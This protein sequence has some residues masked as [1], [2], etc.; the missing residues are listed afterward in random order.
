MPSNLMNFGLQGF[1]TLVWSLGPSIAMSFSPSLSGNGTKFAYD[2]ADCDPLLHLHP[3]RM[4]SLPRNPNGEN[5]VCRVEAR[6]IIYLAI[7]GA[8]EGK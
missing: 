1:C 4:S 8:D 7:F 6:G 5:R 2:D 3:R